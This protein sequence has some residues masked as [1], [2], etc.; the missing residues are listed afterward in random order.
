MKPNLKKKYNCC[1]KCFKNFP[2]EIW[3]KNRG[4]KFCKWERNDINFEG[5]GL[6][7]KNSPFPCYISNNGTLLVNGKLVEIINQN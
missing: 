7:N 4:C 2:K 5:V 3:D 6:V 1:T